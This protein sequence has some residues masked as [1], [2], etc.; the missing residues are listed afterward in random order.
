MMW[1]AY[2]QFQPPIMGGCCGTGAAHIACLAQR[3]SG[4]V[5]E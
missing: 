2:E 5:G 4:S 1:A 3:Y